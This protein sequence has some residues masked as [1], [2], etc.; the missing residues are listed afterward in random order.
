MTAPT[1]SDLVFDEFRKQF[2]HHFLSC[3]VGD[4]DTM[5]FRYRDKEVVNTSAELARKIIE[6]NG[7]SIEVSVDKDVIVHGLP[8]ILQLTYIHKKLPQ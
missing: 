4:D 6:D 3:Y 1:E 7:F 5:I 2:P 8:F